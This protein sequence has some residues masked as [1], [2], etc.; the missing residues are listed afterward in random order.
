M[1]RLEKLC[2]SP[3]L[4][5]S[6]VPFP[7][8]MSSCRAEVSAQTSARPHR[9]S[10]QKQRL[11]KMQT[12]YLMPFFTGIPLRRMTTQP[13]EL[14]TNT[15]KHVTT[16]R[17]SVRVHCHGLGGNSI[18]EA[19]IVQHW[20]FLN[21]IMEALPPL[22]NGALDSREEHAGNRKPLVIG[23]FWDILMKTGNLSGPVVLFFLGTSYNQQWTTVLM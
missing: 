11:A 1:S 3:P 4:Q 23:A 18:F 7:S 6:Q 15:T 14:R 13:P 16:L 5:V 10:F 17:P 9:R 22:W 2:I 12:F 8:L 19:V 20:F 21:V